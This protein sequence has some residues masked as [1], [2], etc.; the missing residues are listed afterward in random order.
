MRLAPPEIA[1]GRRCV[2]DSFENKNLM[3]DDALHI[4]VLS[5]DDRRALRLGLNG[6]RRT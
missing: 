4:A 5:F 3:S 6:C 1:D 2:L